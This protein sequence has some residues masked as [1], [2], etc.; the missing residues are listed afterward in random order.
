M[1][2]HPDFQTARDLLNAANNA[3]KKG[4]IKTAIDLS[5]QCLANIDTL[6]DSD[7]R[8]AMYAAAYKRLI[9]SLDRDN[10]FELMGQIIYEWMRKTSNP[11][12]R[13]DIAANLIKQ[14][15]RIGNLDQASL[16]VDES[17]TLAEQIDYPLGVATILRL[18]AEICWVR[19]QTEQAAMVSLQAL[20]IY[21]RLNDLSG[22]VRALNALG[23][24][25][26][27]MG[28]FFRSIKYS[29][30]A[31]NIAENLGDQPL[32]CIMYSNIGETYQCLYA[33]EIAL[34]YHEKALALSGD[35][36]DADLIR[37]YGVDLVFVGRGDEGVVQLRKALIMA[38]E[39][40][41]SDLV[42][43]CLHS[44]ADA[45]YATQQRA[46]ATQLALELLQLAKPLDAV[47]HIIRALLVLGYCARDDGETTRAQEYLHEGFM[48]AQR[49]AD[50]T[51]IWQ[52]HAALAEMFI[53]VRPELAAVHANIGR[54]MINAIAY[55][56]EDKTLRDAFLNAPPV[57]KIFALKT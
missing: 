45:L 3:H 7:Q 22:Q 32:Q 49:A 1:D 55:S 36:V 40:G 18:R 15:F 5:R 28:N 34:R 14:Q 33:M 37:N 21:E 16:V 24:A 12:D 6:P 47:R 56:V 25:H 13:V 44:L 17:V 20:S 39:S 10:Q 46:E 41:E 57:K 19:G 31:I 53:G 27:A 42:L 9:E 26:Y 43:Q 8:E 29:L 38:R 2:T 4:D 50:K 11:R 23:L 48:F 54:E 51:I 52:T 35:N 30:R